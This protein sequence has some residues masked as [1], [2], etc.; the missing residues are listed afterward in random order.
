MLRDSMTALIDRVRLLINDPAG[1]G[2][3]FSDHELQ[4]FLDR[5]R[6]FVR[7]LELSDAPTYAAGETLY[8]DYMADRGDWEADAVAQDGAFRGLTPA[9]IDYQT[10]HVRFADSQSPPV[11]LTGKV[12][13]VYAAAVDALEAWQAKVA[14]E[15]NFSAAGESFQRS[16]KLAQLERLADVYRRRIRAAGG[17]M[18]LLKRSDM[19]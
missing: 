14:L 18:T 16:Q 12:Y 17:G 4:D 2:Q 19:D 9:S 7:Y 3:V 15:Y 13:D 1:E 8:L 10:G 11:L 5:Q 6:Q